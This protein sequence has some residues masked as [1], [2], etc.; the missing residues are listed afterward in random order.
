MVRQTSPLERGGPL[1]IGGVPVWRWILAWTLLPG[2][3]AQLMRAVRGGFWRGPRVQAHEEDRGDHQALQARRGK[4]GVAGSRASGHYGNGGERLRAP[5][6][7]Y[8]TLSRRRIRCRFS[9]Q[10]KDRDGASRRDGRE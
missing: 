7:P 1:R 3:A 6:G 8:G 4:G 9:T 5:E 10:G 2:G